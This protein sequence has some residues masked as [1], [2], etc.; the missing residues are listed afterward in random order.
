M[1]ESHSFISQHDYVDD[2]SL[3]DKMTLKNSI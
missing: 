3:S 2:D 1:N